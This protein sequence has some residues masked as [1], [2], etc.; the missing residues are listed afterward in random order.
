MKFITALF[1]TLTTFVQGFFGVKT[2]VNINTAPPP[3]NAIKVSLVPTTTGLEI[4][5]LGN[6]Q[7]LSA[8]AIRLVYHYTTTPGTLTITPNPQMFKDNWSFPVKKTTIDAAKKT[9][10]FD[11]AAVNI[12]TTGYLL[13]SDLL[14]AK[15][16]LSGTDQISFDQKETKIYGKDSGEIPLTF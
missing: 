2:P 12:S 11:L 5:L 4:H 3:A 13:S 8:I 15:I 6:N 10:T 9:V 1:L 14:L 16:N 7:N